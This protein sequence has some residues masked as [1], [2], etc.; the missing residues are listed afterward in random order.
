MNLQ[1]EIYRV[2]ITRFLIFCGTFLSDPPNI[3]KFF[4]WYL[5]CAKDIE[6]IPIFFSVCYKG[7]IDFNFWKTWWFVCWS[8]PRWEWVP[9]DAEPRPGSHPVLPWQRPTGSARGQ[10]EPHQ[11]LVT[12]PQ[13]R[14]RLRRSSWQALGP[15]RWH[16]TLPSSPSPGRTS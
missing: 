8:D 3:I 14:R 6:F 15:G 10:G 1:S 7:V 13:P 4:W 12:T 11:T 9:D 5:N 16:H 2:F